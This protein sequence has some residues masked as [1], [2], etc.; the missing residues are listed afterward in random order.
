MP[1][2]THGE[3]AGCA[4]SIRGGFAENYVPS[5]HTQEKCIAGPMPRNVDLSKPRGLPEARTKTEKDSLGHGPSWVAKTSLTSLLRR[6]C[7]KAT[8]KSN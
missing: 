5:L 8:E 3:I 2:L 6:T 1:I 4:K 7:G